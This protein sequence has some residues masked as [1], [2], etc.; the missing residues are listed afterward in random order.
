MP[1][2]YARSW[3]LH[4]WPVPLPPFMPIQKTLASRRESIKLIGKDL[5][6]V[7]EAVDVLKRA[8]MVGANE[9]EDIIASH[10]PEWLDPAMKDVIVSWW[11]ASAPNRVDSVIQGIAD[12]SYL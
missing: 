7:K 9:I 12:G 11:Q 1:I 3:L 2:D 6:D 5:L 4:G 10:P 8:S